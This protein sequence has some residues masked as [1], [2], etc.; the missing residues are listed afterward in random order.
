MDDT[1]SKDGNPAAIESNTVFC[2][3]W[4]HLL[5]TRLSAA[6]RCCAANSLLRG[7]FPPLRD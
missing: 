6:A 1:S 2:L 7:Y 3:Y 5:L 4:R